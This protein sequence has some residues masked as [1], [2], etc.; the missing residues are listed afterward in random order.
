MG[1]LA[2][3]AA[4]EALGGRA[5]GIATALTAQGTRTF[6]VEAVP[7]GMIARQ[8]RAALELEALDAVKLGMIPGREALRAI[9][10]ALR[11]VEVPWVVDPVVRSS[12]G[13]ALSELGARDYLA[14]AGAEVVITPNVPEA[15]WLLGRGEGGEVEALAD[16][17]LRRGF[18]GVVIKGGHRVGAA[19]DV[20]AEPEGV[21]RI[22]GSRLVRSSERRGTG[23]RFGA[24]LAVGLGRGEPLV[25]AA[26][27]AK[28]FVRRYLAR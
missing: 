23:C 14:L 2:D 27:A 16:E 17:L 7:P 1:I 13:Q 10:R 18:G 11:G 9:R 6:A 22:S 28:R 5:V 20:V 4:V 15:A 21:T 12:R 25:D 19:L 24:A 26:R 3:V 8:I